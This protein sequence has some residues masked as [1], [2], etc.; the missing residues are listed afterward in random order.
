MAITA[1]F[2]PLGLR[3]L[4][5]AR[6][7]PAATRLVHGAPD[8]E[9]CW[10]KFQILSQVSG[11]EGPLQFQNNRGRSQLQPGAARAAES[12]RRAA[13]SRGLWAGVVTEGEATS[14]YEQGDPGTVPFIWI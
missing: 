4:P 2:N 3:G 9:N 11:Q 10:R 7:D 5:A 14:D 6:E 12:G 1:I 13:R 8:A